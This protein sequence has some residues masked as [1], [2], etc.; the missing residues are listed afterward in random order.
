MWPEDPNTMIRRGTALGATAGLLKQH[1]APTHERV[2][3]GLDLLDSTLTRARLRTVVERLY[4]FWAGTEPHLAAWL[5]DHPDLAARLDLPRRARCAVLRADLVRLGSPPA[6]QAVAAPVW[7]GGSPAAV[8]GWLYVTE[9]STLGGAVIDRRLRTLAGGHP[10]L[11]SFTPY[12]EGPG[13]MWRRYLD[14]LENWTADDAG[15]TRDVV[16]AAV[17]AF[18]A[19]DAWLEPIRVVAAA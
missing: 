13:P 1:T 15:C 17:A 8:L 12:A 5:G 19:L 3:A 16:D 14:V 6:D 7:T 4:G 10:R 9:G 2:E 11:R 18:A